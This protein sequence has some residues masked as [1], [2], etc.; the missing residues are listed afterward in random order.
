MILLKTQFF[1]FFAVN[2]QV[3][4]IFV[5]PLQLKM[6]NALQLRTDLFT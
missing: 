3:V 2:R 5:V 4:S 1:V 6:R